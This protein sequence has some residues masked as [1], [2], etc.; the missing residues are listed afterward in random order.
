MTV[1]EKQ[2]RFTEMYCSLLLYLLAKRYRIRQKY[3]LR[4]DDCKVGHTTSLH[5][6]GL[7][8]DLVFMDDSGP[9]TDTEQYREA[10]EF[11]EALGG[12]WGGRFYDGGH[13]SLEHN[14]MR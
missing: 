3:L 1:G 14:G 5:K 12:S 6:L 7:A 9:I 4:C 13:F 2:E 8:I 10:G 11:W